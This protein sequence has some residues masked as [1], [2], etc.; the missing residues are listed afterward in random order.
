MGA[1]GNTTA[2]RSAFSRVAAVVLAAS[3]GVL[4]AA[5]GCTAQQSE[6]QQSPQEMQEEQQRSDQQAIE[7]AQAERERAASTPEA[8]QQAEQAAEQLEDT[9]AD[10][11]QGSGETAQQLLSAVW[12]DPMDFGISWDAFAKSYYRDFSWDVISCEGDGQGNATVEVELRVKQMTAAL[13]VMKQAMLDAQ[14]QGIESLDAPY[15]DES[16]EQLSQSADWPLDSIRAQVEL[17]L[18]DGA[19]CI[20]N[21]QVLAASLL[22]G[23]DPRQAS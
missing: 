10:L 18:K 15:A 16:F 9:L 13:A 4:P 14:S 8:Q 2:P 23:Y 6:S 11:S 22:D 12:F 7:A 1:S 17:V 5:S 21:N 20:A 3:I 19:W